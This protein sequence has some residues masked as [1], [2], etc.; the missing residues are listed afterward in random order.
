MQ[1]QAIRTLAEMENLADEWN[2][3]LHHSASD[4]PFLRHEYLKTWFQT[5]G[6][7]EWLHG[8]LYIV[9]A[10]DEQGRLAGIAPLFFTTNREGEPALMLLGSIEI[11]D[12][13]DL[14]YRP[15][16]LRPFLEGLLD[17]LAGPQAPAWRALDWWNFLDASATPAALQEAAARRGWAF[18]Q[19]PLQHCPYIPLPGDWEQYLAGQVDKKQ[20]HEIRRKMRRLESNELPTR[21]YIVE[22]ESTL[23][24]EIEAF[25]TLMA[26]DAN[27]A[28]FLTD[29]MRLQMRLGAWAAW[30]AGY[31][32][33]AFLEVG[34][35]KAAG[36]INFDYGNHIWV[37]NS[38]LN[39]DFYPLS[40][41]WVLLGYLLQWANER[42]RAVFDF[43]RGEEDYKYK[44]GGI[45]R[46]VLRVVVRRP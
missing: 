35:A 3:F 46:R 13:L 26:Y 43:L 10:R 36:Y 18:S 38:G 41:G 8:E 1:F 28:K 7:G 39:F 23:D 22:D 27:K 17:H 24:A 21:W 44:F 14:I 12:Y 45:D 42:G 11:S 9:T 4:V 31:L 34:G 5:L 29:K 37:Y 6:G 19:E 30:K 16:D 20:R 32:Q 25:L 15:A 2:E 40:P 33:L